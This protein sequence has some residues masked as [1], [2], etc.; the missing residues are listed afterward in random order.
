MAGAK[1][2]G[3]LYIMPVGCWSSKC[4]RLIVEHTDIP[5]KAMAMVPVSLI[6][7]HAASSLPKNG[8]RSTTTTTTR[9]V[10]G[11]EETLGTL[12]L[13]DLLVEPNLEQYVKSE[14]FDQECTVQLRKRAVGNHS[15]LHV[16]RRATTHPIT[17]A[18][19]Q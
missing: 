7:R 3:I 12:L 13:E 6:S 1:D 15:S 19:T 17:S 14:Q 9:P 4:F 16:Q 11:Q 18:C 10:W 2:S 5:K 8:P